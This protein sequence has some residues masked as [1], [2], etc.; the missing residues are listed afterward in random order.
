[1]PGESLTAA[2]VGA[3][4]RQIL[5]REPSDAEVEAQL[6]SVD[7]LEGMLRIALDSQEYAD[8]LRH[9]GTAA[10]RHPSVVINT[11]HPDFEPFTFRP[12][13]RSRDGD[14]VVGLE[15]S[16]FLCDGSNSNVAQFTGAAPMAPDWLDR[17][18]Q[19]AG[20]RRAE[21][22]EM[23][24]AEAV[25]V[26]P[27]KLAVLEDRYPEPLARLGPRPIERLLEESE[28][29]LLYPLVEL[30]TAAAEEDVYLTTDT[31]LTFRGN[32]LLAATVLDALGIER[33]DFSAL[34]LNRYL[35]AG[36]LGGKFDPPIV[37]VVAEPGTLHHAQL[38]EDNRAELEAVGAHV[39]TRRVFRNDR[40][41]DGRT[42]AVFGDS[43]GFGDAAYQGLSWF[44]AQVFRE[45]H[46]VWVPFG[47]DPDYV[48]DI[49]AE[50]VVTEGAERFLGQVPSPRTVVA[51]LVAG[52][53][54]RKR[55][56]KTEPV[57]EV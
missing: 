55:P 34:H 38:V 29:D 5:G 43:Y 24:I 31:H 13:T 8:R 15:G 18:R 39:G 7:E 10:V 32:E 37:S 41:A 17:W 36:D 57:S 21:L 16:L 54:A 2:E 44:L 3:V 51:E 25:L 35:I 1:M 48:R 52:V 47:W 27:D 14:A 40:A 20:A 53:L 30:R 6:A 28:L 19:V 4:Y 11:Y 56:M 46:F 12:R 23:G 33:P 9:A 50:V 45:V 49:G 26:V 22:G 42:A